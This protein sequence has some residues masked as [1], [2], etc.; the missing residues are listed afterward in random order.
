M[1]T[2]NIFNNDILKKPIFFYITNKIINQVYELTVEKAIMNFFISGNNYSIKKKFDL[3]YDTEK[4]IFYNSIVI[5]RFMDMFCKIQKVYFALIKFQNICKYKKTPV[6]VDYDLC[7]NQINTTKQ[8]CI[9]IYQNSKLY[10]FL[11]RDLINIINNALTNSPGFFSEPLISKNPYNN[12]P[13]NKSTLYNIYFAIRY[14]SIKIPELVHKFFLTNFNL[15]KF[16][17]EHE[18]LLREYAIENYVKNTPEINL[19]SSVISMLKN[20]NNMVTPKY[21]FCIHKEFPKEQLVKILKPCLMLFFKYSYSLIELIQNKSLCE[22]KIKLKMLKI[23]NQNFGRKFIKFDESK[24]SKLSIYFNDLHIKFNN[25]PI[26]PFLSSHRNDSLSNY[27]P[28]DNNN[29]NN[30][31]IYNNYESDIYESDSDNDS[32]SV[33]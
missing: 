4:N 8:N 11:I 33:S 31:E 3:I 12:L 9:C 23:F 13:F 29:N 32:D 6:Q 10:W 24:N 22:L 21:K 28:N 17:N 1:N 5:N 14:S 18:Y 16:T 7:L 19:Y 25:E 20:Y 30:Y 26:Q 2:T 15:D 27:L